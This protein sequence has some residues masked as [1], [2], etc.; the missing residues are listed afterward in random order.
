MLGLPFSLHVR[1]P[2]GEELLSDEAARYRSRDVD[3]GFTEGV[4]GTMWSISDKL[5][6]GRGKGRVR[7]TVSGTLHGRIVGRL[8]G[9]L[10]ESGD[11][12]FVTRPDPCRS[13]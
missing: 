7:A 4:V 6:A 10:R 5:C 11:A 3:C 1:R 9:G 12:S 13:F 2:V 8:R